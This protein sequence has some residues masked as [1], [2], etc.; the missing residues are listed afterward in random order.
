MCACVCVLFFK[1][2]IIFFFS[3]HPHTWR[4]NADFFLLFIQTA[5]PPPPR[6]PNYL[7]NLF[8]SLPFSPPPP[9]SPCPLLLPDFITFF[10]LPFFFPLL[11]RPPSL[12]PSFFPSHASL[13]PPL[14]PLTLPPTR[15]KWAR[16]L[17]WPPLLH[18]SFLP[19]LY[20]S[21]SFP[22]PL[23]PSPCSPSHPLAPPLRRPEF[24]FTHPSP[25]VP[26]LA[27]RATIKARLRLLCQNISFILA[28]SS[29]GCQGEPSESE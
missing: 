2:P 16:C 28:E 5:P 13:R 3:R 10:F 29:R 7:R 23:L 12:P 4:D 9:S 25:P 22:L 21:F 27:K 18:F 26:P 15:C 19:F 8:F 17:L 20:S 24:I 1:F 14:L 11:F 6:S